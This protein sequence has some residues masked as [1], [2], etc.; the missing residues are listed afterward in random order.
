MIVERKGIAV[1]VIHVLLV[2]S[3][4]AKLLIDR[5][6]YPRVW[7]KTAAYDP[8]L[9][10][11]GRYSSLSLE[12]PTKGDFKPTAQDLKELAEYGQNVGVQHIW[13]QAKLVVENGKL[14]AVPAGENEHGTR[15]PIQVTDTSR[16]LWPE[17]VNYYISEHAEDPSRQPAGT[18]LWAEVTVPKKGPPRPIQ[19]ATSG[20]Q[21]WHVLNLR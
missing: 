21:G 12:L 1:A 10:V 15:T 20:P 17:P 13:R 9:L 11:R 4:G 3:L 14:Y 7:V 6:V 2:C 16:V 8:E 5:K 18:S 19:L